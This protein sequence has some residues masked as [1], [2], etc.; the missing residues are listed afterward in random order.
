L[1]S[2]NECIEQVL[3]AGLPVAREIS[4]IDNIQPGIF[5]GEIDGRSY[6]FTGTATV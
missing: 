2:A 5:S 6:E 1:I 4:S 3:S